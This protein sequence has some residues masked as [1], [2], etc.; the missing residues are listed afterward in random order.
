MKFKGSIHELKVIV[1]E[2]GVSGHW[3][4]EGIF[5]LF[6]SND[7][8]TLNWWP[9]TGVISFQGPPN[10]K[11]RFK[12]LLEE[13]IGVQSSEIGADLQLVINSWPA[14]PDAI[15]TSILT[16]INAIHSGKSNENQ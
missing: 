13:K 4:D 12:A 3:H 10:K 14:L 11:E 9:K 5:Y 6:H 1:T 16:V 7:G 8:V 15:R 2:L